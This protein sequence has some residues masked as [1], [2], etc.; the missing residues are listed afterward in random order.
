MKLTKINLS[1][2]SKYFMVFFIAMM[3]MLPFSLM[4]QEE[5]E[6]QEQEEEEEDPWE[7]VEFPFEDE[8]LLAF[9]DSN[10]GISELQRDTREEMAELTQ[11]HGLSYER[12][13]QIAQ[14]AQI[15]QLDAF[16]SEEVEAF[17]E[18]AP[19]I[20][21]MQREMQG[22]MQLII[23][24]HELDMEDYKEILEEFRKDEQLREYITYLARERAKEKI[25]EERRK[26]AEKELEEKKKQEQNQ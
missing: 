21:E 8:K 9:F 26:E 3:L 17:N 7:D 25:L 6:Q 19:K 13:Q 5:Q 12:F 18:V 23:Q 11:E 4:A 20:T 10:Q 22:E 16:S 2:A 14:A 15:G 24:E 1:V